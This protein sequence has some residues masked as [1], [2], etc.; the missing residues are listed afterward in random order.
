MP[1]IV[2]VSGAR[3]PMAEWIGGKRGDGLPGGALASLSAIDLGAVAARAA[4][5]RAGVPA[6]TIDHV[7]MG[8]AL[9]TSGDA[10][11]GARHVALKAG[12]PKEVPALTVNRLCGSGHQAVVS[13]AQMIATGEATWVVAGGMENMSQA[14]HVLR[15]A[16]GGIRL[17]PGSALEDSLW[18]AL[19]DTTCGLFMAQTSDN[20]AR[21]FGITREQQDEFA[22]RS[23][24]LANAANTN[25][26]FA[27]ERI[28]VTVQQGRKTTVVDKD[29]H[30]F[31]STTLE[32]LSKLAPAF[33]PE[34]FVTAGNASGIVDGAGAVVV[35][36]ADRA[37]A[38]GAKALGHVRAWASVGVEPEIM[39]FG[40]APAIR[41][42]LERAGL[43][44]D[45]VDLF[46]INEA[47]AGQYL[48]VEKDLGLDRDKVN[49]NGG[50]IGLGHPLGATGA[51]LIYTL[52]IELGKRGKRWGIAS[53]CIGG[54][55]G[56]A[57]L[58]ERA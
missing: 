5:E 33:G 41:K 48:A 56:I 55:Q 45:Q 22:L 26:R 37:K 24:T 9:Q 51:R 43:A 23:H 15:G 2:I 30:L 42:A 40:P 7:V 36:T 28:P 25:G 18:V 6:A 4:I 31:P 49:V 34:S 21:K 35:T 8:N 17:G 13:A 16:R 19:K 3:T 46:E 53:A 27:E 47:F 14:P 29:D 39:G 12:V 10:L 20:L 44:L 54:G 50:A 11:Y 58:L 57:V 38:A 1:D 32:G 52:L